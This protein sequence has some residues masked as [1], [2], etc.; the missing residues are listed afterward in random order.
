MTKVVTD[1]A[2]DLP[3]AAAEESG[4]A[5]V[6]GKVM[7]AGS[8]WTGAN[9]ELWQN[10]E[11]SADSARRRR[12]F[13][14]DRPVIM[15]STKAP[16]VEQL[17]V[18]YDTGGDVVAVHVSAELSR[19]FAN[20]SEAAAA[21]AG[22]VRVVDTRSLSVGTAMIAMGVSEALRA[23]F[24]A[25][26]AVATALTWVDQ[27]HVHALIDDVTL[28][29]HGGR[30]GLVE[31]VGD[32]HGHRH[33]MAVRGHA[34]PIRKVRSRPEAIRELIGH[35]REHVGDGVT[36]WAVGH[37]AASDVGE[38]TDRLASIFGCE[39]WFVTEVG[40]PVG[41]HLGPRCLVVGFLSEG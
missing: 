7:L 35:V 28:L 23:G 13:G 19:T 15:P 5:V 11:R 14:G 33:I 25:D 29:V 27:L 24:D 6:R 12:L 31:G 41:S 8:E 4:I 3:D 17:L 37:G 22:R 16:T 32:V 10:L 38:L 40:P 26:R 9:H 36:R 2:A 34:I 30:A 20:A 18:A 39:P 1:G 21:L